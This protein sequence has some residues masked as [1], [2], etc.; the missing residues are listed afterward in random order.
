M[1]HTVLGNFVAVSRNTS[2]SCE[3]PRMTLLQAYLYIF[4]LLRG[5]TFKVLPLSSYALSP[6]MLPATV[7]NIFGTPVLE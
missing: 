1:Q 3:V 5:V 4:I 6:M 7:G 2:F